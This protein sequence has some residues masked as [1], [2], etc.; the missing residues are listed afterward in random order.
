MKRVIIKK[1]GF[2]LIEIM[3][4][5][6]IFSIVVLVATGALLSII[7]ANKKTQALKAVVNNFNFA[8]ENMARNI[9]VGKN[10]H[11]D[12]NIVPQKDRRDCP[13]PGW[14]PSMV[15]KAAETNFTTAYQLNNGAIEKHDNLDNPNESFVPLTS[16]EVE[17]TDLRFYV[18]G[19]APG[20]S[21]DNLQPKVRLV[22]KGKMKNNAKLKLDTTFN[23]QTTLTQ[24][25]LDF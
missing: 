15:F 17:I 6:A 23:I 21:G 20:A 10:Y 11:C 3:V 5:L 16:P 14:E 9:R 22:V 13:S 24:R 18:T 19:N 7:N 12:A 4:S 8:L 1:G 2:S 25:V